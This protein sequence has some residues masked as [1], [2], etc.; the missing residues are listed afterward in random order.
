MDI[1]DDVIEQMNRQ[2]QDTA[3]FPRTVSSRPRANVWRMLDTVLLALRLPL[4]HQRLGKKAPKPALIDQAIQ[5]SLMVLGAYAA[6][7]E[8][9]QAIVSIQDGALRAVSFQPRLHDISWNLPYLISPEAA[10]RTTDGPRPHV[11]IED[12]LALSVKLV[13]AVNGA[14]LG[15]MPDSVSTIRF[16]TRADGTMQVDGIIRETSGAVRHF[17]LDE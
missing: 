5:A 15:K 13:H 12:M 6:A 17:A 16:K 8:T 14:N 2:L 10:T 3:I 9:R 1:P 4:Y 7:S 11:Q